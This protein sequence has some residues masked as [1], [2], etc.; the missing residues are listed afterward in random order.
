VSAV[1]L[2]IRLFVRALLRIFLGI[3]FAYVDDVGDC[4]DQSIIPPDLGDQG[5]VAASILE[6]MDSDGLVDVVGASPQ[7]L[8]ALDLAPGRLVSPLDVVFQV[9][10]RS[11]ARVG[12]FEVVDKVG[13]H[14]FPRVDAVWLEGIDPLAGVAVH[15][16]GKVAGSE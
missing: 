13:A 10:D 16:E 1:T 2:C 8:P 7:L 14:L 6:T 12:A 11:G 9:F 3:A 15:H 4:L 5:I